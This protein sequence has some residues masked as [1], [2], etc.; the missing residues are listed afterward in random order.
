ME[1]DIQVCVNVVEHLTNELQVVD[2]P[3]EI[4]S[5]KLRNHWEK[6]DILIGADYFFKFIKLQN[7][8]ELSSGHMLVERLAP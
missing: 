2:I 6:P 4:Q 3:K 8:Q 1:N 7:V 5:Q